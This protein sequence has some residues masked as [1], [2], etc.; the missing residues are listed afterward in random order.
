MIKEIIHEK[1]RKVSCFYS[2][3]NPKPAF[4]FPHFLPGSWEGLLADEGLGRDSKEEDFSA[5]ISRKAQKFLLTFCLT[6]LKSG[7]YELVKMTDQKEKGKGGKKR[8][9]EER[10]GASLCYQIP[11]IG[12]AKGLV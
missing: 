7:V 10:E 9:K 12:Q 3:C 11:E 6:S 5:G 8:A 1:P 2:H 4:V